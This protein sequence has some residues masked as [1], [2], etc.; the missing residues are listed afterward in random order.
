MCLSSSSV[1]LCRLSVLA[2]GGTIAGVQGSGL[3][4]RAAALDIDT[5]VAAV[6]G[7]D[8]LATLRCEQVCAI[9][10]QDMDEVH[11]VRLLER[12]RTHLAR[13]DCDGVIITHGTDT[14]EETAYFLSLVLGTGKP[15]VLV[16]SM[17]PATAISADGPLNLYN[18]VAVCAHPASSG[19]GV[20]VV[21]ND[22]VHYARAVS[23]TN[24]T[25]VGTFRSLN[26]GLAALAHQGQVHWFSNAAW[27]HG[28][29][30][31]FSTWTPCPL[32]RVEI[33]HAHAGM[34]DCLIRAALAA[35]AKGLV[36]AGVGAGNLH[37]RALAACA[38]AAAAGVVIVRASR[39]GAGLVGR[40]MEVSDD[41]L[42]FIAAGDLNPQKARILL[43]LSLQRTGDAK[44][45]QAWFDSH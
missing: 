19:R 31:D 35:G 44:Q 9:G 23:K 21:S 8:K 37:H 6:P 32:P 3:G 1:S 13:E 45:I 4:Y 2:T 28:V 7:I 34:D 27:K 20:L 24:T 14:M 41:Q 42:G 5:L 29:A 39:T 38:E 40:N 15:V 12:V 17:R 33:L 30:S 36:L 18:A 26:H 22:E 11:W 10:S 43:Q 25:Q 16:G